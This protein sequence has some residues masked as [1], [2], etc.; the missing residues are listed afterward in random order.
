MM[1]TYTTWSDESIFEQVRFLIFT[2]IK[3]KSFLSNLGVNTRAVDMY[4]YKLNLAG[5]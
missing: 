2:R 4:H 1:T 5:S 3:S